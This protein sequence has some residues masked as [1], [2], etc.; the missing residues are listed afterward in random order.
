V[1]RAR[2]GADARPKYEHAARTC[3]RIFVNSR[4]T[5]GEVVELLGVPEERIGSHTP[6]RPALPAGGRSR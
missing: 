6:D 2:D 4:F 1:G 5:G 3:D